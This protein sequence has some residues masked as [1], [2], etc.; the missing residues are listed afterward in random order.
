MSDKYFSR[1]SLVIGIATACLGL[2]AFANTKT[3]SGN[4]LITKNDEYRVTTKRFFGEKVY[5]E[6]RQDLG[7][8]NYE[9][10][11]GLDTNGDHIYEELFIQRKK[12]PQTSKIDITDADRM[13][14]DSI[15]DK[16]PAFIKV[17]REKG[18]QDRAIKLENALEKFETL[19]KEYDK[20]KQPFLEKIS[21][22]RKKCST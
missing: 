20:Y 11:K 22:V 8:G 12:G 10:L 4:N 15:S 16:M 17:L 19:K 6:Y 21:N 13:V 18:D 3:C 5:A 7:D 14:A 9:I 2:Y 1:T